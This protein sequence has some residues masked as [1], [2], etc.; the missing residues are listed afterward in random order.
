MSTH[1]GLFEPYFIHTKPYFASGKQNGT[2]S[3]YLNGVI[4]RIIYMIKAKCHTV[5]R[6]MLFKLE[7]SS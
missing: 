5:N 2:I 7:S 6:K 1:R 3:M 4:S